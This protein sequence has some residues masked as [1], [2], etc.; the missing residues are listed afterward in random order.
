MDSFPL[1]YR[2]ARV[3]QRVAY[4]APN[5]LYNCIPDG[6]A[7]TI[8]EVQSLPSGS[9]R[10]VIRLDES[11]ARYGASG[12]PSRSGIAYLWTKNPSLTWRLLEHEEEELI[13]LPEGGE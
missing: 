5:K 9:L 10:A 11:V 2:N 1:N 8:V 3:G 4:F 13:E 6:S 12:W 7:G